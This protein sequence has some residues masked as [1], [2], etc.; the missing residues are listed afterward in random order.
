[1]NYCY[2]RHCCRCYKIIDEPIYNSS[3]KN[4][5]LPL[6]SLCQGWYDTL[7][8]KPTSCAKKLFRHLRDRNIKADLESKDQYKTIDILIKSALV[9]I[10]VDGS[11]HHLIGATAIRDL[12]RTYYSLK[13]EY[14]TVHI[15]NSAIRHDVETTVKII[16]GI[17]IE[18]KKQLR[19]LRD[20]QLVQS[21]NTQQ[22]LF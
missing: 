1:M 2:D 16:S 15:P 3:L 8:V 17:V 20:L 21:K 13:E 7:P 19:R 12:W 6:C 22:R 14:I 4:V 9:H 18:R 10:E 11:H 5:E